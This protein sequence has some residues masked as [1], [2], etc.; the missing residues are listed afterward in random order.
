MY[1]TASTTETLCCHCATGWT[2]SVILNQTTVSFF[3]SKKSCFYSDG[4]T[5]TK[6]TSY[7]IF[8]IQ[9]RIRQAQSCLLMTFN[10]IKMTVFTEVV[11]CSL[12]ETDIFHL[13]RETDPISEMLHY[14]QNIRW[15]TKSGNPV[16]LTTSPVNF[17]GHKAKREG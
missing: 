2:P 17:R 7:K 6:S 3:T 1:Q 5:P 9:T 10:C 15:W 13:R 8:S 16:I 12:K 14:F 11:P 4:T